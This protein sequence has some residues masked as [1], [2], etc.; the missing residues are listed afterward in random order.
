M[1]TE[2]TYYEVYCDRCRQRLSLDGMTAWENEED[3][4]DAL[5][6]CGWGSQAGHVYCDDCL[7]SGKYQS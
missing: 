4:I 6:Y 7:E 3:A 2:A 5:C 1:I